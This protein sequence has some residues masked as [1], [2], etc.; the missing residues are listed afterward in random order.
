MTLQHNTKVP[1]EKPEIITYSS[2]EIINEIAFA[3][4]CTPS[5]TPL[6]FVN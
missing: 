6:P 4:G 5:P 2:E 3:Q 1:Y